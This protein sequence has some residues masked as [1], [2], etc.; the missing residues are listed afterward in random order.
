LSRWVTTIAKDTEVQVLETE[1]KTVIGGKSTVWVKVISSTGYSGWC[2][3]EFLRK[4]ASNNPN[5]RV[6]TLKRI[7]IE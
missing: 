4:E 2:Y 5:T 3:S 6:D 7:F 1:V